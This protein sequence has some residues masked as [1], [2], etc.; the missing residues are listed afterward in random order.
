MEYDPKL[1][2]DGINTSA[3]HPLRE[4][5]LLVAG[6]VGVALALIAIAALAVDRLVPLVPPALEARVF[7]GL[8][9]AI[10]ADDPRSAPVQALVD[11]LAAHWHDAPYPFHVGVL[12]EPG[13]NALALPGG[14]IL[15]TAGLLEQVASENELA[16]V[17]GHE[18]GHFRDRDHLRGLGRGLAAQLVLG[19]IGG[20][21]ELVSGLSALAGSL[22]QRGFDRRQ[23]RQA[24]AFG[25]ALVQAEYG[26]V[27]G[28][29]DFFARLA[30]AEPET[31]ARG[32]R[33][34]R[35]LDTHPAHDD[36]VA[37]LAAAARANGWPPEGPL[38]PWVKPSAE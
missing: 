18:L 10:A 8:A 12:D 20:S 14:A 34:A 13:P 21:G 1:P 9:Q 23:E 30:G 35:Y 6:L 33:L 38:T 32:R 26:H 7:G 15:V 27:A 16:H 3:E 4:F 29:G 19:A 17:L 25:L 28:A 5:A 11:R 24:D 2:A 31:P 37:A 22:A 36:R